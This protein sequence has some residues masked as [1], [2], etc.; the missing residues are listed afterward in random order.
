MGWEVSAN[1]TARADSVRNALQLRFLSTIKKIKRAG[2]TPFVCAQDR[3][4]LRKTGLAQGTG[5][6]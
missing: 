3:P 6:K 5:S 4:A 2:G 1:V